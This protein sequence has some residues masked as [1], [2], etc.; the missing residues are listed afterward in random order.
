MIDRI[1]GETGAELLSS[2]T[3]DAVRQVADSERRRL[4]LK[5][6][7]YAFSMVPY[8]DRAELERCAPAKGRRLARWNGPDRA[9]G[10]GRVDR[11]ADRERAG[12]TEPTVIKWRPGT[13]RRGWPGWRTR[14]DRRPEDGADREGQ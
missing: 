1:T 8:A 2:V 12:C 5:A 6:E 9:A 3:Q 11:S 4:R 13:P 14:R 10:R 7:S